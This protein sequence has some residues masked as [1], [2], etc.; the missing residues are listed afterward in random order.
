MEVGLEREK[1]V[2]GIAFNNFPV[3]VASYQDF[4]GR[5]RKS[6]VGIGQT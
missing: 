3:M 5:V 1:C 4:C 2:V 6:I